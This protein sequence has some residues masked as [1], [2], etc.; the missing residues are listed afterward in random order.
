V[1]K[2]PDGH[3]FDFFLDFVRQTPGAWI[4]ATCPDRLTVTGPPYDDVVPFTAT[5]VREFPDRVLW[6]T[7]WP[8][9]NLHSHM[10]DDGQIVDF[11]S[12]IAPDP[13]I[14]R[15]LLVDNPM[16]LYWPDRA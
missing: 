4:K 10:P 2:R 5:V 3:E 14:R 11:V 12:R 7:D 15:Q 1:R 6:G 13:D 8:H 9:P 16:R